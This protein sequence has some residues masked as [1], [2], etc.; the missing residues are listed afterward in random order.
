MVSRV[1]D[2]TLISDFTNAVGRLRR[3]QAQAQAEVSSGKQLLEPSDDPVGAARSTQLR[4]E[5]QEL[6][7]YQDSVGL[8]TATLGA[9]D[10][11]LGEVHDMLS[12][13]QEIASS[14]TGGLSTQEARVTASQEVTEIERGL[15][16][17]GNT[18][19]AGRY[20]FGGLSTQGPVFTD[21][22]APGFTPAT[23]YTGPTTPFSVRTARDESVRITTS[24]G[25][26]FGSSLQ[27]LDDLRQTLAAG[28]DPSATLTPLQNAAADISQER[29]SVGGRLARLQSRDSEISDALTTTKTL[30]SGVEDAD[31]TDTIT[32]LVQVQNSLQAT[33]QAGSTLLQTSILNYLKL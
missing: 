21:I 9:E 5:T 26:V 10:T 2:R 1:T 23:A 18:T 11:V 24:G 27:V 33:L 16:A 3:Q 28:N 17:L 14:M 25:D 31:L 12:R 15:I 8:G 32:K 30:L 19:V 7:A 20:V 6:G 13:A 22:S 4:G 29:A